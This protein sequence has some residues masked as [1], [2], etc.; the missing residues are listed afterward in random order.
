MASND[1]LNIKI[2]LAFPDAGVKFQLTTDSGTGAGAAFGLR[3]SDAS[4]GAPVS[5]THEASPA[6]ADWVRGYTR[7]LH[8][9]RVSATHDTQ[10][11]SGTFVKGV[12]PEQVLEG[13]GLACDMIRQRFDPYR[14]S[15]LV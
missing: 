1:D 5:F 2:E 7:W 11:I 14:E 4:S 6:L 15:I 3:V 10:A 13:L 12:T 9:S 8:R